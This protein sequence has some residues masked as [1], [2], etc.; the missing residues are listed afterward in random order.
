MVRKMKVVNLALALVAGAIL[1]SN[2]YGQIT[3]TILFT[4]V[5]SSAAFNSFALAALLHTCSGIGAAPE[6][7]KTGRG[8]FDEGH[9]HAGR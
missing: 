7:R 4:G 1:A 5:G 2:G 8:T 9:K 3:D 6:R